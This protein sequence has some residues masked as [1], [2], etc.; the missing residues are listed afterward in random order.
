M[1]R[2]EGLNVG[3]QSRSSTFSV[4]KRKDTLT[5]KQQNHLSIHYIIIKLDRNLLHE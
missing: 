4:S 3:F 2:E 5:V 1:L